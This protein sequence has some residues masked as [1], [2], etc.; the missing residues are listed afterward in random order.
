LTAT[1]LWMRLSMVAGTAA[2]TLLPWPIA[3]RAS[4]SS[5]YQVLNARDIWQIVRDNLAA[6]SV[7]VVAKL[8]QWMHLVEPFEA[9][10]GWLS[11]SDVADGYTTHG[12]RLFEQNIRKSL[13][14][15][16]VNQELVDTLIRSG[17]IS[18]VSRTVLK[19]LA[20]PHRVRQQ[21]AGTQVGLVESFAHGRL[22][23]PERVGEH[24]GAHRK[25]SARRRVLGAFPPRICLS[26]PIVS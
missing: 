3:V 5:N 17:Q 22:L 6:P 4:G 7:E 21:D 20:E 1:P 19:R 9:Y 24:V 25:R 15:T 2:L 8:D 10:Q 13:G 23:V 18:Q 14:L 16:R 11:A 12:D 26:C